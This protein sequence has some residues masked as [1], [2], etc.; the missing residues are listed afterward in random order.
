MASTC[1]VFPGVSLDCG[2]PL[3]V[4]DVIRECVWSRRELPSAEYC[5]AAERTTTHNHSDAAKLTSS[6]TTF[7]YYFTQPMSPLPSFLASVIL[8]SFVSPHRIGSFSS[9][10]PLYRRAQGRETVTHIFMH[11]WLTQKA[12]YSLCSYL[13]YSDRRITPELIHHSNTQ[14]QFSEVPACRN[15]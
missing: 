9:T 2:S 10:D 5:N 1:F 3:R 11:L 12:V 14:I 13:F 8:F 15:G 4:W 6:P 7:L